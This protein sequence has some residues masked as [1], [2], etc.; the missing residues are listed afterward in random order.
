[1]LLQWKNKT[2]RQFIFEYGSEDTKR[3]MN[4]FVGYMRQKNF[5]FN[6]VIDQ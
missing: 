5:D 3:Y 2:A 1:M 6:W 4:K